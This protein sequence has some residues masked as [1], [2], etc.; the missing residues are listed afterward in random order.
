MIAESFMFDTTKIKAKLNWRPTATNEEM[1]YRAY[2]YYHQHRREIDGRQNV[3][4]HKQPAKMGIIKV[5]KWVS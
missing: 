5:L 4:A 3:S 1:L 2:E